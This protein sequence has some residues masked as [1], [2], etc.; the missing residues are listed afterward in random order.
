MEPASI[1]F[2]GVAKERGIYILYLNRRYI[3]IYMCVDKRHT[4][5][6]GGLPSLS[7]VSFFFNDTNKAI[8]FQPP[9]KK[10][11]WLDTVRLYRATRQVSGLSLRGE[12]N[13]KETGPS[14]KKS[15]KG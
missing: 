5:L 14:K 9:V 7:F 13:I 8:N 1:D 10:K 4:L 2:L 3:Y 12:K 15:Q 11:K 6:R